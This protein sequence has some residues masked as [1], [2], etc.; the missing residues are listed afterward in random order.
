MFAMSSARVA[1]FGFVAIAG[2]PL[3]AEGGEAALEFGEAGLVGAAG[4]VVL[5]DGSDGAICWSGWGGFIRRESGI[6]KGG[7]SCGGGGGVMLQHEAARNVITHARSGVR[8]GWGDMGGPPGGEFAFQGFQFGGGGFFAG[9]RGDAFIAREIGPAFVRAFAFVVGA[10]GGGNEG[11]AFGARGAAGVPSVPADECGDAEREE[12][13]PVQE[14]GEE[15]GHGYTWRPM[16]QAS[17]QSTM[18]P[19][20]M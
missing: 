9:G 17:S 4:E 20:A 3:A 1:G 7:T 11:I 18:A 2:G 12:D 13:A 8:R 10:F 5:F 16:N 19:A 14:E 6:G 15:G